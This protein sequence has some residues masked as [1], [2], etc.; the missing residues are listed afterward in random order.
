MKNIYKK[1]DDRITISEAKRLIRAAS[2]ED[3][4]VDIYVGVGTSGTETADC[5][6]A[7]QRSAG[8]YETSLDSDFIVICEQLK[9]QPRGFWRPVSTDYTAGQYQDETYA[10]THDEFIH[11]VNFYGSKVIIG[12]EP[13]PIVI[14]EGKS[15]ADASIYAHAWYDSTLNAASWWVADDVTAEEAALLLCEFDPHKVAAADADK[16][17]TSQTDPEDFLILRR[18]F[19]G[20]GRTN[21]EPRSL[22]QWRLLAIERGL[23]YHSW[24]DDYAAAKF[25]AVEIAP[26][27]SG[28]AFIPTTE[29]AFSFANLNGW[30]E[31]KWKKNLGTPAKWLERCIAIRGERGKRETLWNP[32]LIGAALVSEKSCSSK[33]IRSKFQTVPYLAPWLDAWKTYQVEFV[34]TV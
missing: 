7:V 5:I 22:N 34:D 14:P 23:K 9:I 17:T 10:I 25:S 24:I 19:E 29:A 16:V 4:F 30:D 27:M 26:V 28:P 13:Q 1:D 32:V 18:V 6:E 21:N 12:I 31:D 8:R 15:V 3:K 20:I 11:L 2:P 33:N